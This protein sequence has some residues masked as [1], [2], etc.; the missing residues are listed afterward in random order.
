MICLTRDEARG[1]FELSCFALL[2]LS[3]E[4]EDDDEHKQYEVLTLP[5]IDT[6]TEENEEQAQSQ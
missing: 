6:T 4:V 2:C 1:G 5:S 3:R